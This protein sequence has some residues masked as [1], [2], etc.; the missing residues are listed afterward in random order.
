MSL[1]DV[2]L[3]LKSTLSALYDCHRSVRQSFLDGQFRN[4][5]SL[6]MMKFT[7]IDAVLMFQYN[8]RALARM[9]VIRI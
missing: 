2:R 1:V 4:D 6:F 3:E 7:T 8:F 5:N 9:L